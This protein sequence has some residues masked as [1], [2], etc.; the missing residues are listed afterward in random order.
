MPGA[1]F[2]LTLWGR[3]CPDLLGA[4]TCCYLSV[5]S[6]LLPPTLTLQEDNKLPRQQDMFHSLILKKI[7]LLGF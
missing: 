4:M 5:V 1:L 2:P 7:L 3:G 6:E